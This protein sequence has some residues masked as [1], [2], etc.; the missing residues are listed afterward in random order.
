MATPTEVVTRNTQ[1]FLGDQHDV[2]LAVRVEWGV[3][4]ASVAKSKGYLWGPHFLPVRAWKQVRTALRRTP[5]DSHDDVGTLAFTSD[6]GRILLSATPAQRKTPTGVVEWFPDDAA[7]LPDV[8]AM[9]TH[10]VPLVTVGRYEFVVNSI[11]F[12]VLLRHVEAG[13]VRSPKFEAELDRLKSV[14]GRNR[15]G[16]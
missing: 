9:E 15:Y 12:R 4:A 5:D 6:D 7:L 2:V 16:G 11:D 8:D 14:L 10:L 1:Q 3:D 13:T